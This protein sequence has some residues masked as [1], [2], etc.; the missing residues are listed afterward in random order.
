LNGI[1]KNDS[2]GCV[3]VSVLASDIL[4]KGFEPC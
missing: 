1:E 3:M 2:I 4:E